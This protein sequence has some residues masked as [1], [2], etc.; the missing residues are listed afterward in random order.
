MK[1]M[2]KI[3]VFVFVACEQKCGDEFSPSLSI[4]LVRKSCLT[5][6]TKIP[7]FLL[8]SIVRDVLMVVHV[9]PSVGVYL[10]WLSW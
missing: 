1:I 8:V 2:H 9:S 6:R 7:I 5:Q 4:R 10:L 3:V